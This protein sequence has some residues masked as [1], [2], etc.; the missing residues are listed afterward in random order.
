MFEIELPYPPSANNLYPSGS[1][2]NRYLSRRGREYHYAVYCLVLA[3]ETRKAPPGRLAVE[4]D[5]YPPDGR[6]RDL[7]NAEKVVTDSLVEAGV[8]ADD[9]LIDL[10]TL[11]RCVQVKGG[12]V[13]VRI[14]GMT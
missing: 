2:R 13:I 8:M 9:S 4:I 11:R 14:K 3:R 12:K 1:A 7:A 10:L 6:K 5:V